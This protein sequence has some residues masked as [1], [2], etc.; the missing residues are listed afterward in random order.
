MIRI[1][2]RVATGIILG[3]LFWQIFIYYP[4]VYFSCLLLGILLVIIIFEWR[5]L[6]N[7][8]QPTF[9]LL[10][11]LYP[12][13]PF[14]CMISMN[15]SLEYRPLLFI[16]FMIVFAHDTGSYI[17]GSLFGKHAVY[18][19]VSP[20]KTWE[21]F[22]GGYLAA[23]ISLFILFWGNNNNKPWWFLLC[24]TLLVCTLSLCG[25]LF[26]SWLKRRVDIKDSGTLLP[27]HG[28]FLDRFDGAMFVAVFFYIFRAYLVAI[29]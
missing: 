1:I 4:P 12:I 19:L 27:G 13:M 2:K 9:W 25:D 22:A 18:P 16:L 17:F 23:C 29:F 24:L 10:M 14:V 3:L 28:G 8:R 26:E 6:F 21:G 11:P 15:H 20:G 5:R 7:L